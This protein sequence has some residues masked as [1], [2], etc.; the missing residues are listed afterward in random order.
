M[1]CLQLSHP[2]GLI[3]NNK[4]RTRTIGRKPEVSGL[5]NMARL[6]ASSTPD[7]TMFSGTRRPTLRS[8]MRFVFIA[9]CFALPPASAKPDSLK[10]VTDANWEDILTG[11]WMIELSVS[12]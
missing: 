12:C 6:S 3:E 7:P 2:L 10:E 5:S 8:W 9:L 4:Q 1:L 11:E